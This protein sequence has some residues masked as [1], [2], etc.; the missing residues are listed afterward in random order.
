MRLRACILN[1]IA[2]WRWVTFGEKSCLRFKWRSLFRDTHLDLSFDEGLG[3]AHFFPLRHI[4]NLVGLKEFEDTPT[5]VFA[6]RF[7]T[8]RAGHCC[9][10]GGMSNFLTQT[11]PFLKEEATPIACYHILL[12]LV[13]CLYDLKTQVHLMKPWVVVECIKLKHSKFNHTLYSVLP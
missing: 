12:M 1:A 13:L 10:L 7:L 2:P 9:L 3:F 11:N 5:M 4:L 6:N 8:Y